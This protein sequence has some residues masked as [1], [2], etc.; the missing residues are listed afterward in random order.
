MSS[1]ALS[2]LQQEDGSYTVVILSLKNQAFSGSEGALVDISV[3]VSSTLPTGSYQLA[4][5]EIMICPLADGLPGISIRQPDFTGNISVENSSGGTNTT[6]ISLAAGNLKAGTNQTVSL[7]LTNGGPVTALQ[8]NIKF[9]EGINVRTL[10][11]EDDEEVPA[12][13]LTN[14]KKSSH[15]LSCNRQEDGSYT[16]VILSLKNHA[17]EG[18]GGALVD[19]SVSV[20]STVATGSYEVSLREIVI[21]PLVN[22]LP[23]I[24]IRQDDFIDR[25]YVENNGGGGVTGPVALSVPFISMKSDS[26]GLCN[27]DMVNDRD[28]CAIQFDIKLPDGVS[29]VEEYNED[30]ELAPS[31]NLTARKKS[32]HQLEFKKRDDGS[33]RVIVFSLQNAVFKDNSGAVV[34]IKIKAG[35][36]MKPGNYGIILSDVLLVTPSEERIAPEDATYTINITDGTGVEE[37]SADRIYCICREGH[38]LVSGLLADDVVEIL[39]INGQK[40]YS[41]ISDGEQLS[42][43]GLD[44]PSFVVVC[45]SREGKRVYVQKMPGFMAK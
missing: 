27:I 34:A 6:Q 30:N 38:Y 29:I 20:A 42:V 32:T 16:V 44:T 4:V 23:G 13:T 45:V 12:I 19:F 31:I 33:Y 21:C 3:A 15:S 1:H 36:N 25:L 18:S 40:L 41:S 8:F 35:R 2:C 43:A 28:I 9:P 17:F 10:T 24:T 7:D 26:E 5:K 14:R 11:N 39:T 37:E 22:G